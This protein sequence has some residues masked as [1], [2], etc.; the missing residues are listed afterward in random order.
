MTDDFVTE[1]QAKLWESNWL[2]PMTFFFKVHILKLNPW[3][4]MYSVIFPPR[5]SC[6]CRSLVLFFPNPFSFCFSF[7]LSLLSYSPLHHCCANGSPV[8]GLCPS[9]SF[10]LSVY[11]LLRI[12]HWQKGKQMEWVCTLLQGWALP[13]GNP[14]TKQT[15]LSSNG[16]EQNQ[17]DSATS[18]WSGFNI[19]GFACDSVAC[20]FS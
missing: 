11:L 15:W 18:G 10:V 5:E 19:A 9:R 8:C 20:T 6:V 14:I 3:T 1:A 2:K 16:S 4:K 12:N 13:I 7:A 17:L